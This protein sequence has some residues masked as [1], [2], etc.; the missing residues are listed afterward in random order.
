MQQRIANDPEGTTLHS[1]LKHAVLAT[2]KRPIWKALMTRDTEMLGEL[3]Q[4]ETLARRSAENF[5]TYFNVL[6]EQELIRPDL[7][8]KHFVYL[9]S[10]ITT[11]FL[12]VDPYLVEEFKVSDETAADLLAETIK[13][14]FA[15][16]APT[17]SEGQQE[18]TQAYNQYVEDGVNLL[19]EEDFK[20]LE[21]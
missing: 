15:S 11:G 2:M 17:T 12:L 19:K 8:M 13:R 16:S 21:S 5:K 7:D 18:L 4:D 9:V 20:E 1:M 6:H 3:A 14:T 10:A